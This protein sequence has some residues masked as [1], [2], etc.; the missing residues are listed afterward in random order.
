MK[1]FKKYFLFISFL[2]SG[3]Y[4]LFAQ[5]GPV[6]SGGEDIGTGGRASFSLGQIDFLTASGSGT[7]FTTEGLQQ[8]YE[9]PASET[10]DNL[11][12][13]VQPNLTTDF[14][15]LTIQNGNLLNMNYAIYDE[16]GKLVQRQQITEIQ[17]SISLVGF[18]EAI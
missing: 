10:T 18:A 9:L 14:I 12:I 4:N 6:A 3:H 11:L 15:V 17:T 8:P 16:H 2:L 5:Q 1:N 13:T 7:E